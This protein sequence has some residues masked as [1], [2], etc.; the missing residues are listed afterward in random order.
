VRSTI[1][2]TLGA[3]F[4]ERRRSRACQLFIYQENS[5][6]RILVTHGGLFRA[7]G[8]IT[9]N[10][11]LS[12]LPWRPQ[13]HDALIYDTLTGVL[14]VHAGTSPERQAYT[15]AFGEALARDPVFF[16]DASCYSFV[17]LRSNHGVFRLADGLSGARITELVIETGDTDCRQITYRGED[18]SDALAGIGPY[19]IPPGEIVRMVCLLRF[20]SG[21]R[22]RKLDMRLPN[23][24][25]YDRE[26]EGEVYE[27][28]I[29]ANELMTDFDER[30]DDLARDLVDAH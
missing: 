18:L 7:D 29:V 30:D 24:A 10:L 5:E 21:G 28:F 8:A 23:T 1:E 11:R 25:E 14:K 19:A 15:R 4:E 3:W 12:R 27:S 13:K 17:S 16:M 20:V 22:E 26:R 2:T 9:S 6:I